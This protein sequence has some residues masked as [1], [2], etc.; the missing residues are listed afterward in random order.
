MTVNSVIPA[1]HTIEKSCGSK[2]QNNC[3][4]YRILN[5]VQDCPARRNS[6]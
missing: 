3:R 2:Q 6:E 4:S 5:T 1:M